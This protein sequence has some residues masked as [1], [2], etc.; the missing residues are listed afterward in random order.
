[1]NTGKIT[2]SEMIAIERELQISKEGYSNA[3]DDAHDKVELA[4][5]AEAYLGD[6]RHIRNR[7]NIVVEFR[8]ALFPWSKKEWKPSDDPIRNLVKAGALI[9]AEI[10]RLKRLRNDI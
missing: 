6:V 10:D 9:P 7:H 4:D 5:A 2:G 3:H 8:P 1:M